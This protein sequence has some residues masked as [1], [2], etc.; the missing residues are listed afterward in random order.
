[1]E[2]KQ[3][4]VN[5]I[6]SNSVHYNTQNKEPSTSFM[7]KLQSQDKEAILKNV[8]DL[9]FSNINAMSIEDMGNTYYNSEEE[10]LLKVLKASTMF[11]TNS[12]M[13]EVI[14]NAVLGQ[15]DINSSKRYLA[16]MMSNRNSYL[17]SSSDGGAWLRQSLISNLE[18]D[19]QKEQIEIE[20]KFLYSMVQFDVS[21]HMSDM[22]NISNKGREDNKDNYGLFSQ[23]DNTYL[24]YQSLLNE[25]EAI[26]SGNKTLLDQQLNSAKLMALN[27]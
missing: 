25:Y 17:S 18:G 2:I 27:F 21:A 6:N 20:K 13:N 3:Q 1:M 7:D 14:F 5:Q 15:G 26:E 9:S 11:S 4:T 8:Q 12:S 16:T 19:V 23:Y 10:N 22:M 24:Q